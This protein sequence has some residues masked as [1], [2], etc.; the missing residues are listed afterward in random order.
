VA[1]KG[2][3][4]GELQR[5][6]SN[7]RE[8]FAVPLVAGSYLEDGHDVSGGSTLFEALGNHSH[9]LPSTQQS[10][11]MHSNFQKSVIKPRV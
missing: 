2:Q 5:H 7:R 6:G 8:H 3:H 1:Q 10:T 4:G 9:D 11:G